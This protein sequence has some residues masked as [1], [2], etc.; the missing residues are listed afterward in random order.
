MEV[1]DPWPKQEAYRTDDLNVNLLG[2]HIPHTDVPF[3]QYLTIFSL[4]APQV[5]A[6]IRPQ[7]QAVNQHDQI[8]ANVVKPSCTKTFLMLLLAT[9]EPRPSKATSEI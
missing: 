8:H 7:Q 6:S 9:T 3:A 1:I 4:A 5:L 2:V